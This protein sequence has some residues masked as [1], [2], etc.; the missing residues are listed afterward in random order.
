V[1]QVFSSVVLMI[2]LAAIYA[3]LNLWNTS[4]PM[5]ELSFLYLCTVG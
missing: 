5:L 3:A 2:I 1:Q 4:R